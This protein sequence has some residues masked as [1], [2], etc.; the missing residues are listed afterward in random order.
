MDA[1]NDPN[2]TRGDFKYAITTKTAITVDYTY[3]GNGDQNKKI[4]GISCNIL[5]LPSVI[6][7]AGKG[8]IKYYYDVTGNK[9]QKRTMDIPPVPM[10][11]QLP[12]ISVGLSIRM[13]RYSSLAHRKEG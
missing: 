8:A 6:M 5:N 11:P 4:T 2:R 1:V 12:P 7:V 9:L 10:Q 13:T 3:D